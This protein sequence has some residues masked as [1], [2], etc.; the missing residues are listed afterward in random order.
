MPAAGPAGPARRLPSPWPA[1]P[2][3]GAWPS[4]CWPP[5]RMT[6]MRSAPS[7]TSQTAASRRMGIHGGALRGPPPR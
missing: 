2:W 3:A 7:S 4:P 5:V 1:R 6:G